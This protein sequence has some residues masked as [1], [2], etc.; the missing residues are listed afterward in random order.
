MYGSISLGFKLI[1]LFCHLLSF[2]ISYDKSY[3]SLLL[4]PA[5]SS[6]KNR[7]NDSILVKEIKFSA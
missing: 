4:K 6:D 1:A 7:D 3:I 2:Y 5:V